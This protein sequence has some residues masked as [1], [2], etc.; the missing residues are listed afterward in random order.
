MSTIFDYRVVEEQKDYSYRVPMSTVK[1]VEDELGVLLGYIHRMIYDNCDSSKR[2]DE[3]SQEIITDIFIP[4]I[5]NAYQDAIE[6]L[7]WGRIPYRRQGRGSSYI[8]R[9]APKRDYQYTDEECEENTED[10]D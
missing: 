9:Y 3:I 4:A 5:K 10:E 2:A 6:Y 1:D 8:P 7:L